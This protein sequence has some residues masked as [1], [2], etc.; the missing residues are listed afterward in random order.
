MQIEIFRST[1]CAPAQP[2]ADA[3]PTA[4]ASDPRTSRE[5]L[6]TLL[7]AAAEALRSAVPFRTAGEAVAWGTDVLG[8]PYPA[9]G[10][11][12]DAVYD[13]LEGAAHHRLTGSLDHLPLR[14]RIRLAADREAEWFHGRALT[15]QARA[16]AHFS[17][18]LPIAEGAA[19]IVAAARVHSVLEPCAGTGSLVRPLLHMPRMQLFLNET[20]PRRRDV[21]AW[22]GF[23]PTD[24]DAL[25][26]PMERVRFDAVLSNPP[27]GA[28]N[29]GH[30]GRG[31]T[32]FAATNI[33]QRFA[34]AHL[35]SLRPHGLLVALLPSSTLSDAGVEFR[36]WLEEHH[37]PLLYLECPE[38]SY[39]TRGALRDAMLLVARQGTSAES[40]VRMVVTS[41]SWDTWTD[42]IAEISARVNG[43]PTAEPG[44]PAAAPSLGRPS[45]TE[46]PPEPVVR[47]APPSP[48]EERPH[49]EAGSHP[50]RRDAAVPPPHTSSPTGS[51]TL[52]L[53]F[54]E[55]EPLPRAT[56]DWD[57]EAQERQAALASNIFAPFV[58]SL[59][60]R[61]APHPRL[62]VETRSMAGMP[63]PPLQRQRFASPLADDAWGRSGEHG[64]ASDE[65]A[66][67]SLRA[68]DA[69]DRGHGFLCADE[70]G[71]GK[72]REIALLILEAIKEGATRILVTTKNENNIRDLE[73]EFRRV[74]SGRQHGPF[75]A[76]IIEVANYRE[77]KGDDGVLPRP[78]GPAIYLAHAHN[79]ADF[80]H[81]LIGVEPTVWLAD[82][83]HEFSNVA[84]SL[85]GIA[86][87]EIH[88]AMLKYTT[89]FA[90]FTATP[91]GTLN[92]LCYFYGLRLWRIGAFDAWLGRKT[93]KV[94][95][96]QT[97]EDTSAAD[98]AVQAH[99]DAAALLGDASGIESETKPKRDYVRADVFAIRTTPAETEQ[100]MRELRGSGHYM[101]RDLWRGGVNFEIEWIGL[102]GNP[103]ALARYNQA[104]ELCRDLS[105]AARQFGLMNEKMPATGLDRAMIQGY[106]KQF[107]FDLRLNAVLRRAD[108]A[109]AQGR[110]VVISI[111]SVAG[112]EEDLE[113]LSGEDQEHSVSHR[114]EAAINR[115]NIQEIRK[116]TTNGETV[117]RDLG[118]IP[119]AL[120]AREELR[121]RAGALDRLRDPVRTIEQHFGAS[122]VAAITGRIPAKLRALRMG[123]F[124]A[125][126]RNVAVISRAGKVGISLHDVIGC[127]VTMLIADYEWTAYMFKQE[128]GRVDRT[129][130][131]TSPEII[132]TAS[133]S[134]AERRFASNIAAHM[135]SL[136]ATCK[137]SAESTGTD[138][139]EVFDMAGGVALEAMRNAVARMSARDRHYFTGSRFLERK[140][141]DTG[142]WEWVPKHRPDPETLMRHFLLE[143]LMFP[144][145]V[146]NSV[147]ALWMEERDKLLTVATIEALAARRTGRRR[148]TVRRERALPARPPLALVDV[149]SDDGEASVIAQ[150]FV[151]E[152]MVMIQEARGPDAE[153]GPRTRRYVQFTAA[154]GRLV[155]GL[156]LTPSEALRVRWAFGIQ[157][158]RDTSPRAIL[159]DLSVG[160]KI[161]VEGPN[162]RTWMLHQRRDGRIQIRGAKVS[163]DQGAL[164]RPSLRGAVAYE[165]AGNF[166]HLT[167]PD[168][169]GP[170][171]ELFPVAQSSGAATATDEPPL[172]AAA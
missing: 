154:D 64:G 22:L 118:E 101:S 152:H 141:T 92:Q 79:L 60:E 162:G 120:I 5:L 15:E 89:R 87:T 7:A 90:Y 75:P 82:E 88:E 46:A 65:Q 140:Q 105:L 159:E 114:L 81:A 145:D 147:L 161:A 19:A 157:E 4:P 165:A 135:A 83:A 95:P 125:G 131:L 137:G 17:T 129:G 168:S 53:E 119:E 50:S 170:F 23:K 113:G 12:L 73:H 149:E 54:G 78:V 143:M 38:A 96:D 110:K 29:R 111:H 142:A 99:R 14:E 112:D 67:L 148:G 115:I 100:V 122:R 52:D 109:L 167:G 172:A 34:A 11:T 28:M 108:Q 3:A 164:T 39:R 158:H 76:Q 41:P 124:Q 74:A 97:T 102:L 6:W 8:L 48:A 160:E 16:E 44:P 13:A 10:W 25:R 150:G 58:V 40:P 61:R 153:G 133:T 51:G 32:E 77:A 68:L 31:A 86:W 33:A 63:A 42:A 36:R 47:S 55:D 71:L 130:Q 144:M 94:D 20:D 116:E 126:I 134:A 146:A 163:R 66:E 59:R 18:P 155:S 9:G 1:P 128:L 80:A 57:R 117:Y 139:L 56:P 2:Q 138:A 132:L 35:R 30:G 156:E 171:L 106:L 121:E 49:Q 107:L 69:W 93:G 91:A 37:T 27:F 84:D 151:T 104:A 72:S 127:G 136:G 45:P 169:L 166:Y 62:V 21:L 103:T 24:R 98:E 123:E 70:V 85:R 43:T 26:L